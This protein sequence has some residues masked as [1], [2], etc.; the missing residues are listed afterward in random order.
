[1]PDRLKDR[2]VLALDT[3]MGACSAALR[4]LQPGGECFSESTPMER[5]HA[6]ALVP[7]IEALIGRAG[8]TYAQIDAIAATTGPGAFTGLR[9]GLA[10]ARAMGRALGKPVIGIT[11]LQAMAREGI[12]RDLLHRDETLILILETKREDFYVQAYDFRGKVLTEPSA[13]AARDIP[14]MGAGRKVVL[15]GDA[16]GR[17]MAQEQ[18]F[19]ARTLPDLTTPDPCCLADI[20]AELFSGRKGEGE[21]PP[22]RPVYL[23]EADVTVSDRPGRTIFK[24]SDA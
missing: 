2:Y 13:V 11:T 3:A 19:E 12:D 20:A 4:S 7:M 16:V 1:M 24:V 17:F 9:I 15:A 14:A 23:R 21:L 8:A 6:E 18:G 22:P 5:G 10:T